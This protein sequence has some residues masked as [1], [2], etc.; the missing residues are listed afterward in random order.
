MIPSHEYIVLSYWPQISIYPYKNNTYRNN[1]RLYIQKST[2]HKRYN[3]ISTKIKQVTF[4]S[5]YYYLISFELRSKYVK[6]PY[7]PVEYTQIN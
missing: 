1:K 3:V 6:I 2:G 7:A 4:M 5:K